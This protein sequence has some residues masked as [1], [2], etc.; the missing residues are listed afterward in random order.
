MVKRY[1]LTE[2]AVQRTAKVVQSSLGRPQP[3][4]GFQAPP[5]INGGTRLLG[6]TTTA[7]AKGA[8]EDIDLYSGGTKGSETSTG[9]TIP[10]VYNRFNSLDSG[11]WVLIDFIDSGWEIYQA[12][13]CAE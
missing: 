3:L 9:E 6:K 1:M 4:R 2:S 5:R 12:D 7:H 10:D 11:T 13:N 8:S